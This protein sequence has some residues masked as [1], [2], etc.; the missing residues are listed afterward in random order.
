MNITEIYNFVSEIAEELPEVES[1]QLKCLRH[2][3]DEV[4]PKIWCRK[5]ALFAS[6]MLSQNKG[7]FKKLLVL[8]SETENAFSRE[9]KTTHVILSLT[10]IALIIWYFHYS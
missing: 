1:K 2:S 8:E 9:I 7:D 6:D 3:L 4:G 5:I 10:L